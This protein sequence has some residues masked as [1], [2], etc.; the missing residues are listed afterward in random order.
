MY[1]EGEGVPPGRM[2]P[3]KNRMTFFRLGPDEVRQRTEQS[4]DGG[5]TWTVTFEGSDRRKN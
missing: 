1:F 2:A 4:S 5:E 3:V